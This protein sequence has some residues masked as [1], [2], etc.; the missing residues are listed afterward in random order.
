MPPIARGLLSFGTSLTTGGGGGGGGGAAPPIPPITPPGM[1]PGTPPGT[2]PTTPPAMDGGRASS[3]IIATSFGISL[4]AVK[5]PASNWRGATFTTLTTAAGGGGGG[6]GGGGAGA[7]S[8]LANCAFGSTSVKIKG[9][10]TRTPT[11]R[12][13]TAKESVTVQLLWVFPTPSTNVC[14]N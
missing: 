13:C 12:I 1:P 14:S 2:P 3:V 4:G 7:I 5:R 6:G 10:K 8:K 9:I 11:T